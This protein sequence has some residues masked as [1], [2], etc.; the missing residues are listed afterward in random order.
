MAGKKHAVLLGP[1]VGE[2]Y[3]EGGRFAQ[4]LPNMISKQYKNRDDIEYIVLT[5]KERFDLYGKFADILV[6]LR[7]PGDYKSLSPNC[8]RLNGLKGGQYHD[9]ANKFKKK[10]QQRYKILKHIYPDV[11]K[12]Q[13]VN[14]NQYRRNELKYVYAPRK[15]NY[16]LVDAY[17]PDQKPIIVLGS[18][19]RKGFKRNWKG[20]Q[21]FYD[22]LWKRKDLLRDFT[23]IICGKEGEYKGDLYDRFYDMNKIQVTENSSLIGILLVILE[24]AFFT[25]G[26][27]SAI[28]NFS[29]L[30]GVDV[31]EFGCQK[32]L[33]TRTYNVK[34]T[35][36]TFIDDRK[37]ASDPAVMLGKLEKLIRRKQRNDRT[38]TKSMATAKQ[39]S[40]PKIKKTADGIQL[41]KS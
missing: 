14:K 16:K 24:R 5:R 6:P 4:M 34:N 32:S 2:L 31:L 38:T 28:P 8:F 7:I 23:F 22:L 25:F 36:I 3:W 10:Y 29:L 15:E 20:W 27:Q 35:P 1:F 33:H 40:V 37:Y 13:Y 39:S 12:G 11:S 21:K 18:R 30:Y 9:I 17:L 19:F 26:S 41:Q